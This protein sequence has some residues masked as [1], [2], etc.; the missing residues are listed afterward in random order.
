MVATMLHHL[1]EPARA[2][3]AFGR[4][5]EL[6]PELAVMP[7]D[8][9]Q[10]YLYFASDLFDAGRAREA[11][12]RLA[13]SPAL[14]THPMLLVLEGV[15]HQGL[16]ELGEAERCWRRALELDASL[17]QAWSSLGKLEMLRNRPAEAV[18]PLERALALSPDDYTTVYNLM[19]ARRRLG[20]KDEVAELQGRLDRIKARSGSPTMSMGSAAA[21]PEDAHD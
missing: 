15:A 11:A 19:M 16:G 5:V 13:A 12:A 8:R 20:Q 4:V 2:A 7:L 10:F 18:A 17:V 9:W 21:L 14:E 3:E 1:N 6:D